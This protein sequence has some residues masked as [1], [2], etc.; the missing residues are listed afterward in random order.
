MGSHIHRSFNPP[1]YYPPL[2]HPLHQRP[3]VALY[4]SPPPNIA[5]LPTRRHLGGESRSLRGLKR[6]AYRVVCNGRPKQFYLSYT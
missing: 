3:E 5:T 2:P 6:F 4:K 1:L